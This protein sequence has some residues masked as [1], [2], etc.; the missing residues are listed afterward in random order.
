MGDETISRGR[1][2][3]WW[4][5]CFFLA[6]V[7]NLI[8]AKQSVKPRFGILLLGGALYSALFFVSWLMGAKADLEEL[9]KGVV[10][11]LRALIEPA[12]ILILL[13]IIL[14][15]LIFFLGWPWF[16]RTLAPL[17]CGIVAGTRWA[18]SEILEEPPPSLKKKEGPSIDVWKP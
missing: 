18:K 3:A 4:I 17:A 5:I 11:G 7:V 16:W 1:A 6:V 15:I 10:D 2:H 12:P 8:M 9:K 14:E 13:V